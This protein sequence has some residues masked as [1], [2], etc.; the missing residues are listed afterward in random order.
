MVL[1]SGGV[2]LDT[3]DTIDFLDQ[4]G[5][6]VLSAVTSDGCRPAMTGGDAIKKGVENLFAGGFFGEGASLDPST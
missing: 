6:K 2:K 1:G 4:V 5:T 3:T